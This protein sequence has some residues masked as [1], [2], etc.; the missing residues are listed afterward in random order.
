MSGALAWL[1]E[2]WETGNPLAPA[3]YVVVDPGVHVPTQ[4]LFQ[5]PDLTR[6]AAPAKIADFLSGAALGNAVQAF[7]QIALDGAHVHVERLRQ[8]VFV[9]TV[10]LVQQRQDVGQ[11]LGQFFSFGAGAAWGGCVHGLRFTK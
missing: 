11:A 6:N 3:W 10:A 4:A 1:Q 8:L 7:A 5:A 9:Q 2:A